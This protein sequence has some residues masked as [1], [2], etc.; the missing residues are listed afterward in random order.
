MNEKLRVGLAKVEFEK[1]SVKDPQGNP[2]P[3]A[4]ALY[5]FLKGCPAQK[6]PKVRLCDYPHSKLLYHLTEQSTLQQL[7]DLFLKGN[8]VKLMS[9]YNHLHS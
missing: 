3:I 6:R 8:L 5:R 7:D 2:L 4:S 9:T 1:E